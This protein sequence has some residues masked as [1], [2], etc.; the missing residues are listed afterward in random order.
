[1]KTSDREFVENLY[2]IILRR[3][4][5]EGGIASGASALETSTN[6]DS[7][8]LNLIE[9]FLASEEYLSRINSNAEAVARIVNYG[10]R[11]RV[12]GLPVKHV[13]SLGTHCL[14]S[15][16]MKSL[17]LR[18]YSLP[19]DWLFTS[20]QT[21]LHCLND[22]FETF[23]DRTHYKTITRDR[24]T[25]DAGADHLFYLKKHK[26]G[27]M[28]THRD[29]S[30]TSDYAYLKRTV[31]RFNH[32]MSSSDA[33]LF[34]MIERPRKRPLWIFRS[35][36]KAISRM[37]TNSAF[38][39]IEMKK[40]TLISGVRSVRLI[41]RRGEHASYEFTPSSEEHGVK[42]NDPIDDLSI[43]RLIHQYEITLD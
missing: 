24:N 38:V 12:N 17:G 14:A 36:S 8:A 22:R 13:I 20:P 3:A 19:F 11:R 39:Y 31:E 9:S 26:V 1:M 35:L 30:M 15:S 21:V 18:R 2:R 37:T 28:F 16:L 33:K 7:A 10:D 27:D 5:D 32:V 4:G 43:V 6:R 41:E 29:P 42:F 34:V 23:L 40:P 25:V